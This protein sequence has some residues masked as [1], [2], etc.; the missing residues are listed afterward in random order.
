MPKIAHSSLAGK[1]MATLIAV[2]FL[3]CHEHVGSETIVYKNRDTLFADR[4]VVIGDLRISG[5]YLT[6]P[7]IITRELLFASNDTISENDLETLLEASS[8][9][10]LNTALFNFVEIHTQADSIFPEI[11]HVHI[12]L[13]ERWY[14]W[15]LPILEVAARNFNEWWKTHDFSKINYGIAV[16]HHNFRGRGENLDLLIRTGF[17]QHF[18]FRYTNRNINRRQTIGLEMG[19]SFMRGQRVAWA[20]VNDKRSLVKYNNY[21]HQSLVADLTFFYRPRIHTTHFFWIQYNQHRF[22][23]TLFDLN[24]A[25]FPGSRSPRFL[26]LG[27]E[28]LSDHRNLKY[29]P[30]SGHYLSFSITRHGLGN[31]S[32]NSIG[33]WNVYGSYKKYLPLMPRWF[34]L[35]GATFKTSYP[36]RQPYIFQQSLGFGYD[37]VRGYEHYVVDGQ[38]FALFRTNL[39]W[40]LL[41]KRT[42]RMRFIPGERFGKLH[43]AV[44][45]G[46]HSDAGWVINSLPTLA[47]NNNLPN[48]FLWG[49]GIGLDLVTYYDKVLRFEYSV[50]LEGNGG[51]FLHFRAPI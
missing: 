44:Y 27:Y 23:D 29:Y 1:R 13:T 26:S 37:Y 33:I 18:S 2:F 50:N 14:I 36:E 10:L 32:N 41:P 16:R 48:T 49:N 46:V 35:A 12:N 11:Y 43:L 25:F 45:L 19:A 34:F 39:K 42:I 47:F 9:N 40:E 20:T 22:A 4:H 3:L 38:H 8:K 30:L 51:L 6:H 7:R 5:N 15:P 24:P 21:L 28:F 31:G 17:D